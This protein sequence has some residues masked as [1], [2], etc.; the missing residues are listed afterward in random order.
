MKHTCNMII[1]ETD[2]SRELFLYSINKSKL[3]FDVLIPVIHKMQRYYK[4]GNFN[5]D[6]AIDAFFPAATECA[7]KYCS[8]F[9]RLPEFPRVFDVT[10]R[11]TCAAE[12][13]DYFMENIEKCDV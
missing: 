1:K 4:K 7:K 3:Y 11:Y 13:V 12:F 6:K 2:E 8:E 10:A 5:K 9:A